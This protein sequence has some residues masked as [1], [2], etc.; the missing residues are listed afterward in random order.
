[1]VLVSGINDKKKKKK[2]TL[3]E[4]SD[5]RVLGV[6]QSHLTPS[7]ARVDVYTT[8]QEELDEIDVVVETSM[9]QTGDPI[10]PTRVDVEGKGNELLSNLHMSRHRSHHQK[11]VTISVFV[12]DVGSISH[13]PID[14]VEVFL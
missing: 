5:Q 12:V 1:M 3:E 9:H 4:L 8:V 11:V 7:I 6:I 10:T 14:N 2:S 13:Q